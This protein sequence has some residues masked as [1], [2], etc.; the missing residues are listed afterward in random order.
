MSRDLASPSSVF[1][2]RLLTHFMEVAASG[3]QDVLCTVVSRPGM[4]AYLDTI[5][6]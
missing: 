2:R 1:G 5:V 3:W 4:Y 6:L